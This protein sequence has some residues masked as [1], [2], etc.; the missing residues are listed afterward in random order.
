MRANL[1]VIRAETEAN[2]PPGDLRFRSLISDADWADLPLSIRRRF[3]RRVA[4]GNTV[5]YV[6]EILET[7]MSVAGWLL[8]QLMRLIGSPFPICRNAHMPCVVSV[9]EDSSL[10]G[11]TWTLLYARRRHFPQTVYS[12]R[13]FAGPTGLEDHVRCGVG[14]TLTLHVVDDALV[15]RSRDYFVEQFGVRIWLPAWMTPGSLSA[16]HAEC[17]DDRFSFTLDV[18]HPRFG[19][20][21]RQMA[22][23]KETHA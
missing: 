17:A 8:A 23:F 2:E 16:T 9:T 22:L 12:S 11:Q 5:V 4:D 15:F 10:G 13:R 18:V 3:S 21:I 7:R 14:V 20:L 19:L 6:G 1:A